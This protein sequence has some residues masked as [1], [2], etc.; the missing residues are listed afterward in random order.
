MHWPLGKGYKTEFRII[1]S[2]AK[3]SQRF[4]RNFT[5]SVDILIKQDI[6][7]PYRYEHDIIKT[8]QFIRGIQLNIKTYNK[9]DK[10]FRYH[11]GCWTKIITGV[12]KK[13]LTLYVQEY[14]QQFMVNHYTFLNVIILIVVYTTWRS[15]IQSRHL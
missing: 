14:I 6:R 4:D 5:L 2:R 11:L 15:C 13:T 12:V 10:K 8:H 1:L 3:W 7:C 9:R